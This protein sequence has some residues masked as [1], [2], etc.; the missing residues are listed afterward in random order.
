MAFKTTSMT[1]NSDDGR[2]ELT[3]KEFKRWLMKFD[4][5]KDGR[6]SRKELRRVLRATGGWF[7]W[8]K[9][10]AGI[11]SADKNGNGFVDGCEIEN[12]VQ[13]AQKELGVRIV[14][15]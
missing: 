5:D 4:S 14:P 9:G 6:I 1:Q 2:R 8:W 15:Y 12:L 10:N 7:T 11:K 3:V 13:F